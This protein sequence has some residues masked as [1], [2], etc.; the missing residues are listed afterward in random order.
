MPSLCH[1]LSLS[2]IK[3]IQ[4]GAHDNVAIELDQPKQHRIFT[5][6]NPPR[7][8]I[9][10]PRFTYGAGDLTALAGNSRYIKAIRHASFDETTSRIV[11]DLADGV[12]YQ[13]AQ[14]RDPNVIAFRLD[15]S[16]PLKLERSNTNSRPSGQKNAW[17][18]RTRDRNQL[19]TS[20]V[21]EENQ[22]NNKPLI[23]IDAGHGGQDPGT[24]GAK[25]REKEITLRYAKSLQNAL[26]ATGKY[27]VSL[28][29]E[30]DK[31]I[32][33]RE[34]FRI[35]RRQK[36]DLFLSLH[37]DSAPSSKASG[38]SI[39]TLSEKSSDA[40]AEALASQENRVDLLA[41]VDLT[42]EDEE[43]AGI[44]IDLTRRETK[45]KSVILAETI[46]TTMKNKVKL[47]TN[48]HRFAG[49]AVLKAPDIPSILI[50]IGFLSNKQEE[51]R[52][53]SADHQKNIVDGITTGVSA[54]FSRWKS[55]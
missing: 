22:A 20:V 8:V 31:F 6:N 34:R 21:R 29:R 10:M 25:S 38:L 13:E 49:F 51:S 1:A 55:E 36:A 32:L 30:T 40:E 11:F 3:I 24:S 48:P 4:N 43:V 53:L 9:D 47:L 7:L 12:N 33:L 39:Y 19:P 16:Q 23:V 50:E 15:S 2:A 17:Q 37:A 28:T 5:L 18:K 44:L 52:I 54:Y 27:R 14:T 41:D 35:A 42:H 46:V 26:L 45:N